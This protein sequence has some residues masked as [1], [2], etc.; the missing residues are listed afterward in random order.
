METVEVVIRIPKDDIETIENLKRQGFASRHEI[1]ILNGT[2]LPKGHGR[3]ID[4]DKLR[5]DARYRREDGVFVYV[6]AVSIS[7]II[8]APTVIEADKDGE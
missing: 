6:P 8:N 4:V 5:C 2:V 7:T 3:L 1:A